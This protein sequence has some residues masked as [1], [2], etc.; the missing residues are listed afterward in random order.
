MVRTNTGR[1]I[2]RWLMRSSTVVA[3]V[4]LLLMQSAAAAEEKLPLIKRLDPQRRAIVLASLAGLVIMGV[5]ML[6]LTWLGARVTRRYMHG[7][8]Y[9]RPT[10]RPDKSDWSPQPLKPGD[11]LADEPEEES[12]S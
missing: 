5:G 10:P 11:K 7:T 8:S 2:R 4:L 3:P 9:F 1:L 6:L 12:G